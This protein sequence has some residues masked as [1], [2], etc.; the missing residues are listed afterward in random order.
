[1]GGVAFLLLCTVG[2]VAIGAALPWMPGMKRGALGPLR[3]FAL[4]AALT[5]VTTHLLPEAAEAM[6]ASALLFFGIGLVLPGLVE[7]VGVWFGRTASSVDDRS[8]HWASAHL[9]YVGL[10]IH[11]L[12]EG[13]ALGAYRSGSAGE[14]ALALAAHTIPLTALVM[15]GFS[16]SIGTTGALLRAMGLAAASAGGILIGGAATPHAHEGAPWMTA[17]AAGLVLHL[18]GHDL[19][20]DAPRTTVLRFFELLALAGGVAIT[21]VGIRA[22]QSVTGDDPLLQQ[23]FVHRLA[24]LAMATAPML[25]V[26]LALGAVVHTRGVAIHGRWF[27]P[28]SVW[29][30]AIRGAAMGAPLPLCACGMLPMARLLHQRGAG[31]PMVVAFLLSTPVVGI[32]TFALTGRFLGWTFAGARFVAAL[33]L[34]VTGALIVEVV[35][36]NL[37]AADVILESVKVTPSHVETTEHLPLLRRFSAAFDEM[38]LHTAPWVMVGLFGAAY[39]DTLLAPDALSQLAGSGKDVLIVTAIAIPSYLCASSATP[40][41][42]VLIAKGMSPGAV[43]AGLLLGPVTNVATAVFIARSYGKRSAIAGLVT[44]VVVTWGL[45]FGANAWLPA[46]PATLSIQAGHEHAPL[47]IAAGVVLLALVTRALWV[48]GARAWVASLV[49][50]HEHGHVHDAEETADVA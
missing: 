18:V 2:S 5:V 22:H 34:A 43:L 11:Q 28:E 31:A 50:V 32:E 12:T 48:S 21:L 10:M 15:M 29:R 13:A 41:A 20:S 35:R 14:V 39:A 23:Q 19:K 3:T 26:G 46:R 45:S 6:G 25:L 17:I 30:Q 24:D 44:L 33:I 27:A 9:G 47:S 42:A 37:P 7:R 49:G 1:M 16:R 40:L 4:A 36:K 8:A 38:M